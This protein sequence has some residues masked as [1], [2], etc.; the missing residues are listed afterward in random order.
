MPGGM[1]MGQKSRFI[2][3]ML[4]A[5]ILSSASASAQEEQA[6]TLGNGEANWIVVE[7]LEKSET[8]ATYM[9]QRITDRTTTV[10]R[11]DSIVLTY[12][13]VHVE[14]DSWLVMHPFIDGKP[15]GTY[16]AGYTFVKSGTNKNIAISLNPAPQ[17]GD[18][19]I[20]MLHKD[21]DKDGVFDFVFV[22]ENVVEDVAVFEGNRMIAHIVTI[23]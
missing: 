15:S 16:I 18:R 4:V 11:G 14:D 1:T 2:L 3:G 9:E 12:P 8:G 6:I 20:V 19:Y 21:A 5:G 10:R 22:E 13:E 7:G 23:P 17:S